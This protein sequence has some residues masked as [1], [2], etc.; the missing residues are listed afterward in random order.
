MDTYYF[1]LHS[2]DRVRIDNSGLDLASRREA[3]R[4]AL[5]FL[6]QTILDGAVANAAWFSK[7]EVRNRSGLVLRVSTAVLVDDSDS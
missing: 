6:G 3:R 2:G 7:I 1:D 4:L 5:E